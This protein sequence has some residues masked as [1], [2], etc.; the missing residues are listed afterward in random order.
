[1]EWEKQH[2]IYERKAY[3][4]VQNHIK[5]ILNKIPVSNTELWNY[6]VVIDISITQEDVYRMYRD[7]Y[8]TIGLNYGNKVNNSL[9]KVKKGKCF[10]Q[11]ELIKGNFTIFVY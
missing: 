8:E 1:M 2:R 11:S 7:I 9:E 6:E 10:I 5:R 4:I 3:R